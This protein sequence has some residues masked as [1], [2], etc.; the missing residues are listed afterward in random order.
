MFIELGRNPA[1]VPFIEKQSH[2]AGSGSQ[3]EA[4]LDEIKE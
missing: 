2:K 1:P 4:V 3:K